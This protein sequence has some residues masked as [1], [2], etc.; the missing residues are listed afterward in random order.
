MPLSNLVFEEAKNRKSAVL[1][2]RA[3]KRLASFCH[4]WYY[5]YAC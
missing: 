2:N 3:N 1:R 4:I 5:A